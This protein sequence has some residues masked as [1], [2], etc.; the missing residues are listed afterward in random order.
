MAAHYQKMD[1]GRHAEIFGERDD[2]G[3]R[4]GRQRRCK[5]CGDWHHV[6]NW[7]H[8][9]LP[10]DWRPPQV[11]PAPMVIHDI[12]THRAEPGVIINSRS[13]QRE[14]MR[15]TGHVEF[16]E[17]A[18]TSGTHKQFAQ[19]GTS[20][21]RDYERDL[22]GDI[23]RALEEDPLN[24][25]PPKMIEQANDEADFEDEHV[26]MDGVEIVGDENPTAA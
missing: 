11:L 4:G 13:D 15:R 10:D 21:Y 24:R 16:E 23:K 1:P 6:D 2:I 25:P 19:K 7:P 17:F 20:A 14:Y 8:N 9:C 18:E 12:E 5:F 22:V 26:T 3:G